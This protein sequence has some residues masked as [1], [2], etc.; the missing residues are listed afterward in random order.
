MEIFFFFGKRA[1]ETMNW[2]IC[3]TINAERKKRFRDQ[4]FKGTFLGARS[5]ISAN[6]NLLLL[7]GILGS[8]HHDIV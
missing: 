3:K 6:L 7:E 4:T 1:M 8:L 5:S 2:N